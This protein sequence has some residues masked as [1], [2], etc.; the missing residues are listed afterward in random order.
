MK[1]TDVNYNSR[2]EKLLKGLIEGNDVTNFAV[3]KDVTPK[4]IQI[5][6]GDANVELLDNGKWEIA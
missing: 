2:F 3:D 5:L 1:I 4:R 6:V